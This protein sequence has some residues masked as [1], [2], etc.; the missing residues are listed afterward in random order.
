[1]YIFISQNLLDNRFINHELEPI[2]D[3]DEL[4]IIASSG[5][6]IIDDKD[7]LDL[8]RQET[9]F[10]PLELNPNSNNQIAGRYLLIKRVICN[11]KFQKEIEQA[12]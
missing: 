3:E 2:L 1:M 8:F 11:M 10:C 7:D 5:Y 6:H 12:V 9:G 4:A